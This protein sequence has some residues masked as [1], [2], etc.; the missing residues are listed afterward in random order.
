M[1]HNHLEVT[2][3]P[4]VTNN[5]ERTQLKGTLMEGE[6]LDPRMNNEVCIELVEEIKVSPYPRKGGV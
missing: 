4:L 1:L 3:S 2:P 6:D 5:I